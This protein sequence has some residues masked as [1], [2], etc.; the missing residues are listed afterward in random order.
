V[1]VDHVSREVST[2]NAVIR[3]S[4][5]GQ[6]RVAVIGI[7][8]YRAWP[9]LNN[10]VTDARGA[11][12]AFERLGF[13]QACPPLLDGDATR[14]ALDDLVT[15]GLRTLDGNDSLVVFFAGHGH[16]IT[17]TYPDGTLT[18]K[19]YLLPV[20][21]EP[22]EGRIGSWLKLD[23]WLSELSHLPPRH[24][25]VIVDAC[26][27]GIALDPVV[28]WRG[29]DTR[30]SEPMETLRARRSRRIITSALD[31]QSAL[32]SGPM[33]GHSLFTG[34]LIEALAGAL[35][36]RSRERIAT[37]SQLGLHLQR[38]VSSFPSS[39]QTPDFGALELDNRGEL[40][41]DLL[42][43]PDPDKD[44]PAPRRDSNRQPSGPHEI[45]SGKRA[46]DAGAGAKG[47]TSNG[48]APR[49][50]GGVDSI[51]SRPPNGRSS[52]RI[53]VEQDAP[54]APVTTTVSP[55]TA[56][57][58]AAAPPVDLA[59][60]PPAPAPVTP[61]APPAPEPR[62][63]RSVTVLDAAFVATLDRH[64][65]ARRHGGP[66][67]TLITAEPTT[68]VTGW[69][70]WAAK[71][72]QLTLVCEATGLDAAIASLFEQMPWLRMLP[73][74]RARLA[75]AARLD[76]KDVDQ[77]LDV[78]SAA[79][80]DAWLDQVTGHDLHARV[81]G[82]LLSALREAWAQVPDL[83]TA[84]VRGGEL[85]AILCDLETPISVLFQ[86][87]EPSAEWLERAV[88]TAIELTTYL[89]RHA[90][91]VGAPADL[92]A[93]VIRA[94]PESA[95]LMIAKRGE[96]PL[97]SRAPRMQDHSQAR[98]E[99]VL[100][101]ALARDARTAGLFEMNVRVPI[102]DGV[103]GVD[104]VARDAL[105]ALEIDDWYHHRDAHGH[106]RARVK[107]LGL[108]RA[109]FFVMRF[110][111]EDIEDR[112]AQVVEEIALGLAGRRASGA[113]FAE[114]DQ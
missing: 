58:P 56:T 19:G 32:D 70:T 92:A 113:F 71:K 66:I 26:H 4:R 49:P 65:A 25:L 111:V 77:A 69:A 63:Q 22:V 14:A 112:L 64:V 45:W 86:H 51:K 81:S 99:Q 107:D 30:L 15:D 24:I 11:L 39:A 84:P 60:P 33:V 50:G 20:D 16:T 108:Q 6:N 28:R 36:E 104:L 68:A 98:T 91:A 27:S 46:P 93:R 23:S 96:V 89:P 100:H 59:V 17:T 61:A 94:H 78:P 114:R 106:H 21:A 103:V 1:A 10:A 13:K 102:Y 80:R 62:P 109:G 76:P 31:T 7:D 110:L 44:S 40:I 43:S 37:G 55:G 2:P 29:E 9:T 79:E 85:L 82:W 57:S 18:K 47:G 75:R 73:A 90:V 54:I 48:T 72:G 88:H 12:A 42:P 67:L 87:P 5:R 74:S 3:S 41:F 38:R 53:D 101:D 83:L 8:R 35:Y 97:A 52:P 34:C 105:L 95:S